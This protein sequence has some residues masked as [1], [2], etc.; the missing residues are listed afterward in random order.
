MAVTNNN[1][2]T[3]VQNQII[4]EQIRQQQIQNQTSETNNQINEVAAAPVTESVTQ[5]EPSIPASETAQVQELAFAADNTKAS[6]NAALDSSPALG[7]DVVAIVSPPPTLPPIDNPVNVDL[8]KLTPPATLKNPDHADYNPEFNLGTK[9]DDVFSGRGQLT[10]D[11][12]IQLAMRGTS[13]YGSNSSLSSNLRDDFYLHNNN[14]GV[15]ND[16]TYLSDHA[17]QVVEKLGA[18]GMATVLSDPSAELDG[19]GKIIDK[20]REMGKF[21]DG[22]MYQLAK[23][24]LETPTAHRDGKTYTELNTE[25]D[26]KNANNELAPEFSFEKKGY[27]GKSAYM[28]TGISNLDQFFN[29]GSTEMKEMWNKGLGEAMNDVVAPK[30]QIVAGQIQPT[31]NGR[32]L[33]NQLSKM[34]EGDA[35]LALRSFILST[36][37]KAVNA[38][39]YSF[40]EDVNTNV[41]YLNAAFSNSS[42]E[43]KDKMAGYLAAGATYKDSLIGQNSAQ[44]AANLSEMVKLTRN[45]QFQG[46]FALKSAYLADNYRKDGSGDDRIAVAMA[47]N[48]VSKNPEQL[49]L[50]LNTP[51]FTKEVNYGH[52]AN[53]KDGYNSNGQYQPRFANSLTEALNTASSNGFGQRFFLSMANYSENMNRNSQVSMV[54]YFNNSGNSLTNLLSSDNAVKL[55][56]FFGHAVLQDDER[57]KPTFSPGG[58]FDQILQNALKRTQ[59]DPRTAA[60]MSA[61]LIGA[62]FKGADIVKSG[63]DNVRNLGNYLGDT[64]GGSIGFAVNFGKNPIDAIDLG[65]SGAKIGEALADIQNSQA[66]NVPDFVKGVGRGFNKAIQ[67]LSDQLMRTS[68][69]LKKEGKLEKS[70][71]LFKRSTELKD[72]FLNRFASELSLFTTLN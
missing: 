56:K 1:A 39:T 69:T 67:N 12:T 51:E 6:L 16:A 65:P 61:H 10:A 66:N 40:G 11:E 17:S 24:A 4:A 64:L 45:S 46:T 70:D 50:L 72:I 36:P 22:D 28:D 71:E 27:M 7:T 34:S 68:E 60:E 30:T 15:I 5:P 41:K 54:N 31:E 9:R 58:G 49:K 23:A 38:L 53:F 25:Y 26:T 43:N 48:T 63:A 14:L 33:A 20:M 47:L 44:R 21:N 42:E 29:S 19:W 18:K 52:I 55:G 35:G 13:I 3:G 62:L 8:G 32:N 57:N 37:D 2:D 59:S